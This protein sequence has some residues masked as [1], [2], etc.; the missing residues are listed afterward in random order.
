MS[1]RRITRALTACV[2]CLVI[3]LAGFSSARA[4]EITTDDGVCT[5]RLSPAETESGLALS[6]VFAANWSAEILRDVP[7]VA[8][9][10][11][12]ARTW[13]ADKTSEQLAD[14]PGNVRAA[15]ERINAASARVGYRDGEAA[16]PLRILVE[17]NNHRAAGRD[18]YQMTSAEARAQLAAARRSGS[19]TLLSGTREGLSVAAD[20][21]WLRAWERTPGAQA[22]ADAYRAELRM[23]ATGASGTV[24]RDEPPTTPVRSSTPDPTTAPTP[25]RGVPLGSIHTSLVVA[26]LE[27]AGSLKGLFH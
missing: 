15:L 4:A 20:E 8:E 25:A 22:E 27:D 14:M 6:G 10:M 9:D 24:D 19:T 11:A 18:T 7:S 12:L 2:A 5:V 26:L 17:R 13:H 3:P 1:R 16:A 21:A 23:C